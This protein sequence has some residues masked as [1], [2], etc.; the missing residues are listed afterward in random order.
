[1][2]R[3]FAEHYL[4]EA[5]DRLTSGRRALE[6]GRHGTSIF[7][8][9]ECVEFA[10]KAVMET[11]SI[12]YP[13]VHDVSDLVLKLEK[14]T[15]L[16]PWFKKRARQVAKVVAE[17]ASKRI[18]SRYGDQIRK[19]PPSK[20]FDRGDAERAVADAEEVYELSRKFVKWWF[21]ER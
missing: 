9:Q 14:D 18:I 21:K 2:S 5:K 13:P 1:M 20:L 12:K 3:E 8:S 16:P 11:L 10:V 7:Y 19:I 4:E 15:R 6:E 17:L